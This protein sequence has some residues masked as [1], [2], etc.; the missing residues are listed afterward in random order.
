M[1]CKLIYFLGIREENMGK[2]RECGTDKIGTK[3]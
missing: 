2:E 1:K 3:I